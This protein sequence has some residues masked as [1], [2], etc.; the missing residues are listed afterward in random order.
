[1]NFN[2]IILG[3]GV[4]GSES[5]FEFV[6]GTKIKNLNLAIIEKKINNI[7]GGVAYSKSNSKYGFFNNPLRISNLEF[8]K[9]VKRKKNINKLIEFI[10]FNPSYDLNGWLSQNLDF[11]FKRVNKFSEIY[12]PR[13]MYSFFLEEKIIKTINL[14]RKKSIKI[15]F[16]QGNI[17]NIRKKKSIII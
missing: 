4:I 17:T 16:Y 7:P 12:F 11:K 2:I 1:M 9:W 13:L 15:K 14:A 8:I 3:F 6:K 5:L 10:K